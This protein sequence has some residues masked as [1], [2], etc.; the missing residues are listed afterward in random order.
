MFHCNG[1]FPDDGRERWHDVCL[2][3][4]EVTATILDAI[5]DEKVTHH[6]GAPIVTQC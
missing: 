5:R 1:W 3:K 2:R 6:C 4:V